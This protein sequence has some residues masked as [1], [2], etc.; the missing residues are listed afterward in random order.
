[1]FAPAEFTPSFAPVPAPAA[2][3]VLVVDD[4]ASVRISLEFL[5]GTRGYTVLL[6]ENAA[7]AVARM[8][9]QVVDAALVDLHMPDTNGCEICRRLAA[10]AAASGRAI[11]LW[12]MTAAHTTE[13]A[14]RAMKAGAV[15]LL[16]KPFDCEDLCRAID[17]RLATPVF[18]FPMQGTTPAGRSG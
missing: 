15:G 6:A 17:E 9:T 13:A 12:L 10:H 8:Q 14:Q 18:V 16:K 5:L 1:M 7:A 11:P 2:R 4:Q 3:T